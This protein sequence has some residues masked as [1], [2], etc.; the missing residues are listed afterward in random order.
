MPHAICVSGSTAEYATNQVAASTRL[1]QSAASH[2]PEPGE[3][4]V[5]AIFL[6]WKEGAANYAKIVLTPFSV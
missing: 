5:R 4:G 6:L 2:E 3:K 1:V